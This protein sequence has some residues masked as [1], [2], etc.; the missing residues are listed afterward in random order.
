M[1]I[2]VMDNHQKLTRQIR[3]RL[4]DRIVHEQNRRYEKL[5]QV[6]QVITSEIDMDRLFSVIMEETNR[7]LDSERST[8]FLYDDAE[9]E[10]WSLV[11]T[12][13]NR[14]EIRIPAN[15]GVAG[16]VFQ[17]R[18]PIIVKDTGRDTRFFSEVDSQTGFQT[19]DIAAVPLINREGACIGV[20]EALNKSAGIFDAEDLQLL[21]A[22]SNYAAIAL[23]NARLYDEVKEYSDKLKKAVEDID[24]L[25]RM[26]SQLTKFV[27]SSIKKMV[28]ESYTEIGCEK[29]PMDI[30][31]LFLD[32]QGFSRLTEL[33]DQL[34]VNDMV[35]TYFSEYLDC[36][37]RHGGEINETSGDGLMVIFKD[38]AT[39]ENARRAVRA[40]VEI[41]SKTGE[42]N[43]I[44]DYPWGEVNLHMGINSGV[45]WVGCTRMKG[46][47]GERYTYT[48]SGFPTV[49]AARIGAMSTD[50]RL[51]CGDNT[52][53]CVKSICEV[54]CLGP[55]KAKNVEEP[56]T[57]YWI[58]DLKISDL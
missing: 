44:R 38:D 2:A 29:S 46:L 55:R 56:V 25:E 36:I 1:G 35:E 42:L 23:E 48:A 37:N 22:M 26:K 16:G 43:R 52:F 11:A 47:A 33:Y 24:S 32:I 20:L 30:S 58:K 14:E 3:R 40:G 8:I 27:P 41:V 39:E 34:M 10:L 21:S 50:T 5:L 12:G 15:T 53:A 54:E 57:V 19:K 13:M 51:Y 6:G 18:E 45:A 28:E 9:D 49:L 31:V 17:H 7:I 4:E